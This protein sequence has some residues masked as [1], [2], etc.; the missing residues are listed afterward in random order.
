MAG[1][2]LR[3]PGFTYTAFGAK[4]KKEYISLNKQEINKSII[5]N[6]MD[7]T[8]TRFNGLYIFY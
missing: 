4:L 3:Q 2:H 7:T 6:M 1:I 8:W 5:Q